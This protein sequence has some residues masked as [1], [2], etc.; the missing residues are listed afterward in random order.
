[1]E[2]LRSICSVTGSLEPQTLELEVK[3]TLLSSFDGASVCESESV[4]MEDAVSMDESIHGWAKLSRSVGD[5]GS[6]ATLISVPEISAVS[7]ECNECGRFVLASHAMWSA[8]GVAAVRV[9]CLKFKDPQEL[10]KYLV[11]RAMKRLH[12]QKSKADITVI[13]VDINHALFI[14][15]VAASEE[16]EKDANKDVQCSLS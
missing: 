2:L 12:T 13:V 10:A 6:P 3:D 11:H 9:A 16:A 5:D 4:S 1:M 8:I 15:A 7:I 14:K